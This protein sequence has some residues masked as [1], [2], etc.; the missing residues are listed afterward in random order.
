MPHPINPAHT[1]P[2]V[3]TT[4]TAVLAANQ[5]RT[6]ALIVNDGAVDIYLNLGGTAVANTGIRV[7]AAGGSYEMNED[8]LFRG[9]SFQNGY[10]TPGSEDINLGSHS[11]RTTHSVNTSISPR[12][13]IHTAC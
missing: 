8:N 10:R 11:P 4:S 9:L 3:P 5:A 12:L 13:L 6:Y 1:A 2:S 7:N